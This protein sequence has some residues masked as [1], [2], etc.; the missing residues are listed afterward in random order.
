MADIEQHGCIVLRG[1]SG[2]CVASA[3]Q[4]G[5]VQQRSGIA[6]FT[7]NAFTG[8]LK[9]EGIAISMDGRGR[10]LDNIFVERLWRSV[11]YEDVYLQGYGTMGELTIGLARYFA[12]HNGERPHQSLG[13]RTPH[14][15]YASGRGSGA[16]IVDKFGRA[17]EESLA[18][19]R[20][21]RNFSRSETGQRCSAASEV[22]DA[23]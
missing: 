22:M 11:K 15:V 16:K 7:S 18:S 8:V 5:G 10:A 20:C 6:Q 23:A 2:R 3:R 13:N 9:R 12:F 4:A 17:R 21:A 14:E 19:L 1:L